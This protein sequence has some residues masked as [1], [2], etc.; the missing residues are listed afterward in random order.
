[1]QTV[2][3]GQTYYFNEKEHNTFIGKY[4]DYRVF[5]V[6]LSEIATKKIGHFL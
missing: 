6:Y 2:T 3:R 5:N 1:M 4:P